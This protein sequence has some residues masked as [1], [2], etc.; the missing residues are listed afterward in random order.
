ML[1]MGSIEV[2]DVEDRCKLKRNSIAT[3]VGQAYFHCMADMGGMGSLAL[4]AFIAYEAAFTGY[5]RR[6]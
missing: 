1:R 4:R 6:R 5:E 3:G 2:T